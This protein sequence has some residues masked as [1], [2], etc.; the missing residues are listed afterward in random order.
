MQTTDGKSA[1]LMALW[2]SKVDRLWIV[3]GKKEHM[4]V[5]RATGLQTPSSTRDGDGHIAQ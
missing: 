5:P 2:L 1:H 3:T 4:C